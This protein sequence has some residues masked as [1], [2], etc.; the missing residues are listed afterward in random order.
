[1]GLYLFRVIMGHVQYEILP[2][3]PAKH[4]INHLH[5]VK[6]ISGQQQHVVFFVFFQQS[7]GSKH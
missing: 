3:S 4:I 6:E 5:A 7:N 2:S 1:M